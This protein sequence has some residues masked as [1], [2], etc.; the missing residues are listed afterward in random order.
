MVLVVSRDFALRREMEDTPVEPATI[1]PANDR[2]AALDTVVVN[3]ER[4][5]S[6]E[7][8]RQAPKPTRFPLF[9][10]GRR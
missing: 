6:R 2:A 4:E 1:P 8:F 7:L 9:G 3:A 10:F 5:E